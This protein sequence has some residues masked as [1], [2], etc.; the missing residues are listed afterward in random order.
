MRGFYR[1]LKYAFPFLC[2]ALILSMPV[3]LLG[4]KIVLV[5]VAEFQ[6]RFEASPTNQRAK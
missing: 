2:T 5:F 6:R 3:E 4:R 1:Q